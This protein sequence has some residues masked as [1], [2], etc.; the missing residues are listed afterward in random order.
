MTSLAQGPQLGGDRAGLK[1]FLH[2][3]QELCHT[4]ALGTLSAGVLGFLLVTPLTL[5]RQQNRRS[6]VIGCE[7]IW[8]DQRGL[9]H[10]GGFLE[11]EVRLG[12]AGGHA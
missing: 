10:Q 12:K 1:S 7:T 5:I 8:T 4:I 2:S 11:D 9:S 3:G 6:H